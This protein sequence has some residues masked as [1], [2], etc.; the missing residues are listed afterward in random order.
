[1]TY[2]YRSSGHIV[3]LRER[4][5]SKETREH[6]LVDAK[7]T[8]VDPRVPERRLELKQQWEGTMSDWLRQNDEPVR[9]AGAEDQERR[10]RRMDLSCVFTGPLNMTRRKQELED[11]AIALALSR[12]GRKRDIL[13]RIMTEFEANPELKSDPRFEALFNSRPQKRARISEVPVAG[14]SHQR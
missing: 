6:A 1:M 7:K 5:R 11:I 2:C 4:L 9:K 13:E 8:N 3:R 10:K 12:K 14:P